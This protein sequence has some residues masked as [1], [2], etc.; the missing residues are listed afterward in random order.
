MLTGQFLPAIDEE[1]CVRQVKGLIDEVEQLT[2]YLDIPWVTES[3]KARL[4]MH[5]DVG[6]SGVC[7]FG[8]HFTAYHGTIIVPELAIPRLV[9]PAEA[10]G[11]VGLA[12][13]HHLAEGAFQLFM[14]VTKPVFVVAESRDA[15]LA[16]K[17]GLSLTHLWQTKVVE[18][19]VSRN[20]R[21]VV[22]AEE[23]PRLGYVGPLGE[24]RAPPFVVMW[25]GMILGQ[26][27]CYDLR[28]HCLY[29][30]FAFMN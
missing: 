11:E 19:Q 12:A 16:C 26:V 21:L 28:C 30:I 7:L 10:E 6:K 17:G 20:L 8:K 1:C 2:S 14:A 4:K 27:E 18:S 3:L 29:L 5:V 22:A 13:L 23:W 24:T 9:G 15:S 25:R